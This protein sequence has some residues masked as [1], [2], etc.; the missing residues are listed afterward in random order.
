MGIIY[1]NVRRFSSFKSSGRFWQSWAHFYVDC[2]WNDSQWSSSWAANFPSTWL[3]PS[4]V[5][6]FLDVSAFDIGF[7]MRYCYIPLPKGGRGLLGP[8]VV[9]F[10]P[11]LYQREKTFVIVRSTMPWQVLRLSIPET[12]SDHYPPS[13]NRVTSIR[14]KRQRSSFS[15][16]QQRRV[17]SYARI[18]DTK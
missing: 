15:G 17:N 3:K 2:N 16:S 1:Y 6:G 9:P 4:W 11:R 18:N 10:S 13:K 5:G 14:K 8:E 7:S 12:E